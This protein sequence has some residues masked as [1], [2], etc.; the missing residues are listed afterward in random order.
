MLVTAGSLKRSA[1][2]GKGTLEG[3]ELAEAETNALVVGA[4]NN[5]IPKLVAEDMPVFKEILEETFPG[6]EVAKM[7]NEGSPCSHSIQNTKR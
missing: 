7:E 2:E 3:D 4:C 1:L 5:I 6:S